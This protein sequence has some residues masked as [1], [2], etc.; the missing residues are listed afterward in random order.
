MS[1]T[2]SCGVSCWK[3]QSVLTHFQ[4]GWAVFIGSTRT[5][6]PIISYSALPPMQYGFL[7]S[8]IIGDIPQ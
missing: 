1:F 8:D 2:A 7:S 4:F 6:F 3:L 5:V